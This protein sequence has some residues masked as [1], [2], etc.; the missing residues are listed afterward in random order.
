[1][2]MLIGLVMPDSGSILVNGA[3]V[4]I[5]DPV[6]AASFGI[7]MVHQHFSLVEALSVWE[8][9]A[10][11]DTGRLSQTGVRNAVGELSERYGLRIDSDARVADLPVG[12]RQRVRFSSV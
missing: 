8:N 4:R 11:G 12:L 9:V 7:G 3:S 6:V 1:M 2:K 10:L 5:T